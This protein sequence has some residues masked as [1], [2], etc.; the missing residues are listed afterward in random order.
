MT[1]N[2]ADRRSL[3]SVLLGLALIA[4]VLGILTILPFQGGGF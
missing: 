2:H 4:V 3:G 1:S